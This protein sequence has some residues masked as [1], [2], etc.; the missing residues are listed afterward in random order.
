MQTATALRSSGCEHCGG[1]G[2]AEFFL[3]TWL[4]CIAVYHVTQVIVI[5]DG[6]PTGTFCSFTPTVLHS[7]CCTQWYSFRIYCDFILNRAAS[8][9]GDTALI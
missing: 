2:A 8:R 3:K 5:T 7:T 1:S 9:L 6:E 4:T